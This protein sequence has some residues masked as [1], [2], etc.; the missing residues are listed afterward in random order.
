LRL[1]EKVNLFRNLRFAIAVD[2][3][4]EGLTPSP[5]DPMILMLQQMERGV[6]ELF[7]QVEVGRRVRA[8][9]LADMRKGRS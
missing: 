9:R 7:N 1:E 4:T 5:V 3:M 2:R 8:M 6:C